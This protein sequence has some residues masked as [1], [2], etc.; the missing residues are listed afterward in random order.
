MTDPKLA[1]HVSKQVFI[2]EVNEENFKTFLSF[3]PIS[4]L[5]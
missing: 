1:P 2:S 4:E 3:K 5:P